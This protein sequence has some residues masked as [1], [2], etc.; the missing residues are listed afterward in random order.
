MRKRLETYSKSLDGDYSVRK[1]T[2][3]MHNAL[4]DKVSSHKNLEDL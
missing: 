2:Y 1:F 3:F 4:Q